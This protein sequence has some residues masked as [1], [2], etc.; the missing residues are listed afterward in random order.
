MFGRPI[1][2]GRRSLKLEVVWAG[3]MLEVIPDCC[4]AAAAARLSNCPGGLYP[5]ELSEG[6]V[7]KVCSAWRLGIWVELVAPG[8]Y[9]PA[10]AC[11]KSSEGSLYVEADDGDIGSELGARLRESSRLGKCK[12]SRCGESVRVASADGVG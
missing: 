12:L 2:A 5:S 4:T 11:G 3:S 8:Q 10:C 6:G 1:A 9:A 7:G